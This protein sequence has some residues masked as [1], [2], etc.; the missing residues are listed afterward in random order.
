MRRRLGFFACLGRFAVTQ[1]KGA[2]EKTNG[3]S[4]RKD[5]CNSLVIFNEIARP[6][7]REANTTQTVTSTVEFA[8]PTFSSGSRSLIGR[9]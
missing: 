8:T 1:K 5:Q 3:P 4:M 2:I 9:Q 6:N 7:F